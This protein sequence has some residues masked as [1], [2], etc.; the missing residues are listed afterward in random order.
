[1]LI[2]H[3]VR[4]GIDIISLIGR[5]DAQSAPGVNQE[6]GIVLDDKRGKMLI[7]FKELDYISSSGLRVLIAVS[8]QLKAVRGSLVLCN[9]DKKIYEVFDVS[10]FTAIFD[11]STTQEEALS[12]LG[13]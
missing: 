12:M 5:I 3:E 11:I 4:D 8:K 6:I 9:L 7:D 13:D 1:M 10:G 2:E